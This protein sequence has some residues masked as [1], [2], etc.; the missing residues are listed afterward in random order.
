[1]N[2]LTA[3]FF[4]TLKWSLWRFVIF[5]RFRQ[6]GKLRNMRLFRRRPI[7]CTELCRGS[8]WCCPVWLSVCRY[9]SPSVGLSVRM[10]VGVSVRLSVCLSVRQSACLSVRPSIRLSVCLSVCRS[11]SPP[12][13]L[14]VHLSVRQFVRLSV[15]LSVFNEDMTVWT[16]SIQN[17]NKCNSTCQGT[18]KG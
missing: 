8:Q 1:M 12:V 15:C 11:I 13:H 14:S 10:F 18:L 16:V 9:V 2:P 5:W 3:E 17:S 4:V 7:Y 6:N